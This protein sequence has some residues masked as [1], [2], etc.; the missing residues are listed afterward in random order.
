MVYHWKY[1]L[2]K[3]IYAGNTLTI[4]GKQK[5]ELDIKDFQP[6]YSLKSCSMIVSKKMSSIPKTALYHDI[7]ISLL[8]NTHITIRQP[9]YLLG[10]NNVSTITTCEVIIDRF[11]IANER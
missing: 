7:T 8:H 4:P 2:W 3:A 11:C 6:F 9:M 1:I 5:R 10:G